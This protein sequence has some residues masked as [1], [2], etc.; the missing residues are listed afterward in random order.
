MNMKRI[1]EAHGWAEPAE[2]PVVPQAAET[3]CY[4]LIDSPAWTPLWHQYALAVVRLTD[5]L[6]G[7]PKS[8]HKF[9]GSTHEVMM[10]ALNP[11]AGEWASADELMGRIVTAKAWSPYLKPVNYVEQFEATDDEMRTMM[12][13]LARAVIAGYYNPEPTTYQ[14]DMRADWLSALTKTMAHIR[15]EEHDRRVP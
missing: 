13:Y 4:W 5:G 6:E 14:G 11:A 10:W 7:F 3:V 15:G 1:V 2:I 8:Y 9:D 12:W